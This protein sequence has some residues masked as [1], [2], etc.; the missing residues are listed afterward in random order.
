[1]TSSLIARLPKGATLTDESWAD[2]HRLLTRVL[3]GQLPLLALLGVL[4]PRSWLLVAGF[5]AALALLGVVAGRPGLSQGVRAGAMGL[6]LIGTSFAAI[7]LSGGSVHMHLHLLST[8][9]LV[10]LYQSWAALLWTLGAILVH[11]LTLGLLVPGRVFSTGG[12][13]MP[14]MAGHSMELPFGS[15]L[16]MVLFH[17]ATV[18]LLVAAVLMIWHFAEKT[19]AQVAEQSAAATRATLDAERERQQLLAGQAEAQHA[20]SL[21]LASTAQQIADRISEIQQASRVSAEGVT[22]V[23]AQVA[24]LLSAAQEIAERSQAASAT[25]ETGRLA[26]QTAQTDIAGLGG[27]TAQIA[28]VNTV[29]SRL[30]AQTS[31]LSLNATIEAARAGEAGR[32]F[33]VVAGEVKGLAQET[34][35]SVGTVD[36]VLGEVVTRAGVVSTSFAATSRSIEDINES[37]VSIAAAVEEQ[38]ALLGEARRS[39]AMVAEAAREIDRSVSELDG[40]AAGLREG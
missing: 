16:Y 8:V 19:E 18:G 32:G 28:E 14:E 1:M 15:V 29:I 11:H 31:L 27:S 39:L 7:D 9:A 3:W 34:A 13:G 21:R 40:M 35:A 26:A 23:E 38:S 6:A 10:A 25:A 22:S 36:V 33:A 20:A 30:A 12:V 5:V 17:A 2:R 24:E 37:Q 4:G